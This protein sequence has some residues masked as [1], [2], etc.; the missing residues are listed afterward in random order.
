MGVK[1][2]ITLTRDEAIAQIESDIK[3]IFSFSNSSLEYILEVLAEA[4]NR[5]FDNFTVYSE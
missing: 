3:K 2:T 1:S 5:H 4:D